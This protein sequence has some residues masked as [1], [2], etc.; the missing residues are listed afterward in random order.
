MDEPSTMLRSSGVES[1]LVGEFTDSQ[2]LRDMNNRTKYLTCYTSNTS[3]VIHKI[4]QFIKIN[5]LNKIFNNYS[6][7]YFYKYNYT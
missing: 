6:H 1:S 4:F 3:V 7:N 2:G 5:Y